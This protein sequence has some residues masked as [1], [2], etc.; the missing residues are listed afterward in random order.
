MSKMESKHSIGVAFHLRCS[1]YRKLLLDKKKG[2]DRFLVGRGAWIEGKDSGF[3]YDDVWDNKPFIPLPPGQQPLP[4][5][6]R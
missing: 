3:R 5:T 4:P 2:T 6:F 1:L